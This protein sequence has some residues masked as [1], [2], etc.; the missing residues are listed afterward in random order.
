VDADERAA[1]GPENE[2]AAR[3]IVVVWNRSDTFWQV[4]LPA[5][6]EDARWYRVVDTATWLEGS[7]NSHATGD[8]AAM[9]GGTYGTHAR[10]MVVLVER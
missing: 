9:P 8:W 1:D 5:A 7:G 3:S 2:S 6:A 4:T 10:S